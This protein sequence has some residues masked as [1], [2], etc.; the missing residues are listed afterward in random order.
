MHVGRSMLD[1]TKRRHLEHT[2][3]ARI[4]RK[5]IASYIRLRLVRPHAQIRI[6]IECEVRA[7]MATI[8]FRLIEEH[9]HAADL[10]R[11]HGLLVASFVPVIRGIA[12]K[13][14]S[15]ESGNAHR[16]PIDIDLFA[17]Q[18]FYKQSTVATNSTDHGDNHL[19]TVA[20][21]DR[22]SEW[23]VD[24]LFQC[25]GAAIPELREQKT[26]LTISNVPISFSSYD[27]PV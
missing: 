1:F 21:L 23:A 7:L 8:A 27:L 6:R 2:A 4:L 16:N 25:G 24:P 9:R 12:R 3:I 14:R 17:A 19:V 13:D 11:R 18:R 5:L 20:H 15:F 10:I 26:A 22:I